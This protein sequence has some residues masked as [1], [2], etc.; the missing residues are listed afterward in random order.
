M[1]RGKN[2]R[3]REGDEGRWMDDRVSSIPPSSAS[4]GLERHVEPL[5]RKGGPR[6]KLLAFT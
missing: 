2:D 3:W 1:Q 6:M 5:S 4:T